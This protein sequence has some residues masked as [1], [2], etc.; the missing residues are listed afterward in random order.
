MLLPSDEREILFCACSLSWTVE[1]IAFNFGVSPEVVKLRLHD[2]L[3]RLVVHGAS[4]PPG[5]P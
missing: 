2:A 4:H 5:M 3:R 1:R